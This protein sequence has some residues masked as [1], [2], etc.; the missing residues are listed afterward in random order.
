M[1]LL[2]LH[3][4]ELQGGPPAR[5]QAGKLRPQE[6]RQI[7]SPGRPGLPGS[8]GHPGSS[9][10]ARELGARGVRESLGTA[11]SEPWP[12]RHPS[13]LP[14]DKLFCSPGA[15][16]ISPALEKY[17]INFEGCVADGGRARMAPLRAC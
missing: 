13:N 3:R 1:S 10:T 2:Q 11:A 6:G 4:R 5:G 15:E 8:Q 14:A 16:A 7:E 17:Y 12:G 9:C